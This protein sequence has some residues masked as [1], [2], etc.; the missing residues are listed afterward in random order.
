MGWRPTKQAWPPSIIA[1]QTMRNQK[2]MKATGVGS[3]SAVEFVCL[4][5]IAA[6][7]IAI[8]KIKRA[9]EYRHCKLEM[10]YSRTD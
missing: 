1:N 2:I 3:P 10:Q 4:E 9:M 5:K 8:E 7:T 6:I